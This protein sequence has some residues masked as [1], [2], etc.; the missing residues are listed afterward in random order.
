MKKFFRLIAG[1]LLWGIIAGLLLS[2]L[3]P[4]INPK[5]FWPIVFFGLTFQIWYIAGI[6]MWI[7][8]FNRGLKRGM[9]M[10][11]VLLMGLPYVHRMV[12]F[13][14]DKNPGEHNLNVVSFNTW[15]FG[16][17]KQNPD[18]IAQFL[19]SNQVDFATLF[20]LNQD[21][22]KVKPKTLPYKRSNA[23]HG[24]YCGV[25]IFS[26]YPIIRSE[27]LPLPSTYSDA[28]FTDIVR[29]KDTIRIYS[30][31]LES[32]RIKPDD[33]HKMKQLNLDDN[34]QVHAQGIV[35]RLKQASQK[36]A[37]QS[38][39]LSQHM[40]TSPY[41]VI[42]CMDLNDTPNSYAYRQLRGDRS[43]SFVEGG[44]GWGAT[45]QKPFPFLRIDYILHDPYFRCTS[46]RKYSGINSDHQLIFARL[47]NR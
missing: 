10:T 21:Y 26:R 32:N 37:G 13:S 16:K 8:A 20:E 23:V 39:L 15:G 34:Y 45:Y 35:R 9:I 28:I 4:F 47:T 1:L 6:L 19:D 38:D 33:Y 22:G 17:D 44:Q 30:L 24:W 40:S 3:A 42:I 27:N 14:G 2:Y 18:R 41:P 12:G 31:H 43:D 29:D 7:P 5:H 46:F 11:A 25:Q 36:R